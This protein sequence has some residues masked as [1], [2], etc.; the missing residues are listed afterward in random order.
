MDK[1]TGEQWESEMNGES[2]ME[3]YTL[4][5]A[6]QVARGNLVYDWEPKLGLC[7]KLEGWERMGGEREVQEGGDL[8]LIHVDV[9]Q[10]SIL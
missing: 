2:S 3:A 8:W 10:K 1:G 4:T 9:W 5:Y 7:H 6:K